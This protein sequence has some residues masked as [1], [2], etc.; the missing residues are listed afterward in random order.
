MIAT[1]V[2]AIAVLG[3]CFVAGIVRSEEDPAAA[4]T[5]QLKGLTQM[6]G[7][8]V[9]D[10]YGP[11][12][13]E[14]ISVS[15]GSFSLLRPGYFAWDIQSPDS[16]LIIA[17]LDYVWHFDRDLETVTRRPVDTGATA[18]PLQVLGGDIETLRQNYSI[19]SLPDGVFRLVPRD[20]QAGFKALTLSLPGG[21]LQGMVVV[22]GLG[23]RLDIRFS[24]LTTEAGLTPADF[25]FT[26]PEG[27]DLFYHEQ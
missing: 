22:D 15:K 27:V 9:Q 14:L 1:R 24:E 3:L 5:A 20:D 12:S 25:A 4:L 21:A 6:T 23:Q 19:A 8:F 7:Q 16:Q 17:D 18:S 13:D 2:L 10:Q 11:G 26:P